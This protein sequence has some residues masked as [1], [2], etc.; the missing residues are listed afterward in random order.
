MWICDT[1]YYILVQF[2]KNSD[3]VYEFMYSSYKLIKIVKI[4]LYV[5]YIIYIPGI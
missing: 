4:T 2:N 3:L 5:W 1:L